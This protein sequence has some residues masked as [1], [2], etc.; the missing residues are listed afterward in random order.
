M[1][2]TAR[3][4]TTAPNG[5]PLDEQPAWRQ[6]FP[7]DWPQDHFVARRDFTKFLVLTSLPFALVQIGLGERDKAIAS[8]EQGYTDRDQWMLYLKVDPHMDTLRQDPRFKDLL[9][10]VGIPQ[11]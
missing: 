1:D 8:L 7:I 2:E 3:K 5:L 4:S 6:D 10:R 9:R 11:L